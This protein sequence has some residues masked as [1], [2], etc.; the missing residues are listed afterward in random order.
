MC[1]DCKAVTASAL[2]Y[3]A[4]GQS[5]QSA[6]NT[7]HRPTAR[8]PKRRPRRPPPDRRRPRDHR[9]R[10]PPPTTADCDRQPPRPR[11]PP[12]QTAEYCWSKIR[13]FWLCPWSALVGLWSTRTRRGFSTEI[14]QAKRAASVSPSCSFPQ[15]EPATTQL[16]TSVELGRGREGYE[17]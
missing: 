17:G 15:P 5:A 13:L 16:F 1:A 3:S 12:T 2:N 7:D 11:R 4:S 14:T 6:S 9:H 10:P 8:I